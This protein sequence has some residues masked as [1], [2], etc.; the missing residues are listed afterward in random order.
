MA[1][2]GGITPHGIQKAFLQLHMI[3]LFYVVPLK[4]SVNFYILPVE[5]ILIWYL[6]VEDLKLI[7]R[8]FYKSFHICAQPINHLRFHRF[9]NLL[10]SYTFRS[11]NA[12]FICEVSSTYRPWLKGSWLMS[13]LVSFF[14]EDLI[15][16]LL[17]LSLH[18]IWL[19]LK[20]IVSGDL[21]C[22]PFALDWRSIYFFYLLSRQFI[23]IFCYFTCHPSSTFKSPPRIFFQFFSFIF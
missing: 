2:E 19:I 3:P 9:E 12:R 5:C 17:L 18:A 15:H 8:L 4:R 11:K 14:L 16:L 22:I 7:L 23:W 1:W 10:I 20:L 21:S 6:L 13:H